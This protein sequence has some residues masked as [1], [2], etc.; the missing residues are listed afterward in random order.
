[1]CNRNRRKHDKTILFS[2]AVLR[3][4]YF[5]LHFKQMIF[6]IRFDGMC[7]K[8]QLPQQQMKTFNS[9]PTLDPNPNPNPILNP[10]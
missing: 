5:F 10:K 1:M 6:F 2:A 7:S 8:D 3:Q 9:N 4:C